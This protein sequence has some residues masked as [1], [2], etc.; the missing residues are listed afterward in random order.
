MFSNSPVLFQL[1]FTRFAKVKYDLF[2]WILCFFSPTSA[3]ASENVLK[4]SLLALQD[5]PPPVLGG[6]LS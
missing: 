1:H 6:C 2:L 3:A 4:T 5:L